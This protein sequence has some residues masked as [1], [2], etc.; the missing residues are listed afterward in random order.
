MILYGI[1]QLVEADW[2]HCTWIVKWNVNRRHRTMNG[3]ENDAEL[4]YTAAE[5]RRWQWNY[6]NHESISSLTWNSIALELESSTTLSFCVWIA[7]HALTYLVALSWHFHRM[8]WKYFH[9]LHSF[10][11]LLIFSHS[12]LIGVQ[13]TFQNGLCGEKLLAEW[14]KKWMRN[15]LLCG[16]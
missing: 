13:W 7:I 10:F 5:A 9:S 8:M 6:L 12:L 15:Q 14:G 1:L 2:V 3:V 11:C 4:F 16:N